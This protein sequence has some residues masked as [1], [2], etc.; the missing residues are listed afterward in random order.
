MSQNL[1]NKVVEEANILGYWG[2]S[3]DFI[4]TSNLLKG[5]KY[6][7]YVEHT[8]STSAVTNQLRT[9][10]Y[11]DM[12]LE[13]CAVYYRNNFNYD[14]SLKYLKGMSQINLNMAIEV[15]LQYIKF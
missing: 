10:D 14:E 15:K 2:S 4:Y 7:R 3:L 5:K 11:Q 13:L 9:H 8:I 1:L 6:D 12:T